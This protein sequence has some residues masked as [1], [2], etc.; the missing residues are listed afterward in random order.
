[1]SSSD[2]VNVIKDF[3]NNTLSTLG[4]VKGSLALAGL[5]IIMIVL[6]VYAVYGF[7]KFLRFTLRLKPHEFALAILAIGFALIVIAILLP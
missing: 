3:I 2:A 4:G 7:I 1:M 5:A 6:I